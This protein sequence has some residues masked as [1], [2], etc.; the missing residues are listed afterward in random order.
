MIMVM[1]DRKWRA[2]WYFFKGDVLMQLVL[3]VCRSSGKTV[4]R[5]ESKKEKAKWQNV[6]RQDGAM[7]GVLSRSDRL[8]DDWRAVTIC[9][10]FCPYLGLQSAGQEECPSSARSLS[11]ARR[12]WDKE[13]IR[14]RWASSGQTNQRTERAKRA[15]LTESGRGKRDRQIESATKLMNWF[16]GQTNC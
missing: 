6:W 13:S 9:A 10:T 5:S 11:K 12:R 7:I 4:T 2:T 8:A 1:N 3:G 16:Q 15:E 14:T